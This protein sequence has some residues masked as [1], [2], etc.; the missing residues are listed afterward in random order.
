M[1]YDGVLA[2]VNVVG[3]VAG[4]LWPVHVQQEG[5]KEVETFC[6]QYPTYNQDPAVHQGHRARE[7]NHHQEDEDRDEHEDDDHSEDQSSRLGTEV[8]HIRYGGDLEGHQGS[9]KDLKELGE[10]SSWS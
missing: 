7:G 5:R 6:Y 1:H 3:E 8:E 10:H 2:V 4:R 9:V